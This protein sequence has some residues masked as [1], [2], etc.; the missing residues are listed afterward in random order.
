[1]KPDDNDQNAS[2]CVCPGCPTFNDCMGGK[3]ERLFC[4]R[5]KTDCGPAANGCL[6]GECPV[7]SANSLGDYYYCKEGAAK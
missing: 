6:C 5:G 2:R 1:M 7:W 3:H 4:S